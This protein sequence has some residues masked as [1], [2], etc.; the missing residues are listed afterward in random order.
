[1]K[2]PDFVEG[3]IAPM[4]TVFQ[5]DGSLDDAGQRRFLDY[6]LQSGSISAYFIRSGMGLMYTF[7]KED[8][9]QLTRNVCAH[10]KGSAPVLVGCNGIWD[11]NYDKRPDPKNY[12]EESVELGNFALETGADAVVYTMPEAL[13]PKEGQ[14][15]QAL[16]EGFFTDVCARV[17]GPVFVYQ[18]PNTH[19]DY[20]V[21]PETL[22]KIA[23]ID[24]FVGGKFS[25]SDGFYMYEL[26]RATRE[27]EFAYIM[28]HECIYYAGL[29]LGATAVIGQGTILHPQLFHAALK[30]YRAGDWAGVLTA[31]DAI[32]RLVV[33]IGKPVDF[34]KRYASDQGFD[35]PLYSRSQSSN[36]YM[37]DSVP[38][39]DEEYARFKAIFEKEMQPYL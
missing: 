39:T 9:R 14:S 5:A 35:V 25:T 8:T 19:K 32:N 10:I 20:E 11:R 12:V 2:V 26:M 17:D 36:P 31:E 22:A 4:F 23:A 27:Q 33:G 7:S 28:G 3:P 18:P 29:T 6:L 1:M 16:I 30:A 38:L 37:S 15:H 21:R 13:V 24:N 34:L